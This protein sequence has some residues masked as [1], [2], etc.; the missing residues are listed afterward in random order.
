MF[1]A[2]KPVR[3]GRLLSIFVRLVETSCAFPNLWHTIQQPG[4]LAAQP[5]KPT[6]LYCINASYPYS[7]CKRTAAGGAWT[8]LL[9][10][11]H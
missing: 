1:C 9:R 11:R 10:R 6:G 7:L 2:Q 5:D 3:M 8:Q 4:A